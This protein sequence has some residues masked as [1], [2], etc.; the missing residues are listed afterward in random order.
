MTKSSGAPR[1]LPEFSTSV[2]DYL[3][4][5]Y[6]LTEGGEVASTNAIA[7]RLRLAAPSVTGM[8]KRLAEQGL[9]RH[10]PYRGAELTTSGRRAALRTVRRHRILEAYLV[11]FLGYDWAHVHDEAERLEHA[12]SDELV[13]RMAHALGNPGVDPHGDPIPAP[14]GTIAEVVYTPLTD[15]REGPA[16][17]RRVQV[18]DAELL[19]Y[20]ASVGL[21][22]GADLVVVA[23]APFAGPVTVQIGAHRQVVGRELAELLLC[24]QGPAR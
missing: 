20:L 13:E 8:V 14:D 1:T 22:P 2:E 9:V 6:H 23:H 15:L 19:R 11:A 12:V 3:K 4:T 21:V 24:H 10:E 18:E 7:Q 16:T 5:I 17:I